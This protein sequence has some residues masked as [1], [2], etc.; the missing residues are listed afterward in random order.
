MSGAIY[1][2]G[3]M[4]RNYTTLLENILK[5][6]GASF[7]IFFILSF[8]FITACGGGRGGSTDANGNP[9]G[10]GLEIRKVSGDN[11]G[12]KK[13]LPF[14]LPLVA[15]VTAPDGYPVPDMTVDCTD[16]AGTDGAITGKTSF[17]TDKSGLITINR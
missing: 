11:Q 8:V 10:L 1:L 15:K 6:A 7:K 13:G 2:R 3:Q 9:I 17:V 14:P 16:I 5:G 4:G 12:V